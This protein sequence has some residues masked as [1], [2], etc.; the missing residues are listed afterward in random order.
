MFRTTI[1]K[2]YLKR[3]IRPLYAFSQ[4]T[5]I[6]GYLDP[7]W[8]R[9]QALWPGM[10][11]MRSGGDNFLPVD[12]TGV[13]YGLLAQYI[14][15]DGIDE[16]LDAGINAIAVWTL[17]TDAQFEIDSPAFDASLTW[18]D[19]T[20][21]TALLIHAYTGASSTK[22]G[23]LVPSTA[24]NKTAKPIARLAKVNSASTITVQG[25]S[26]PSAY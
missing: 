10:V 4:A 26:L 19:P 2:A 18:T 16:P 9:S 13:P 21:G 6:S 8:D 11:M 17:N 3:T 12:A 20:D 23:Q 25:L 24:S 22:R 14:G 5:P 7:S 1:A 15:G